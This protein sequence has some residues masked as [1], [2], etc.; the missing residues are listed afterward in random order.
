LKWITPLSER[1]LPDSP[2]VMRVPQLDE[3]LAGIWMPD[4]GI[5]EML[6]AQDQL[7]HSRL[8]K[9]VLACDT[10]LR[11]EAVRAEGCEERA[12]RFGRRGGTRWIVCPARD[13]CEPDRAKAAA[14]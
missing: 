13:A 8:A 7:V 4:A 9:G 14:P 5:G 3:V 1:R 2:E 6:C 10:D 11:E 12:R